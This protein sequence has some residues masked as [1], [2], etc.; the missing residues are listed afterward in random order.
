MS[1]KDADNSDNDVDVNQ[2]DKPL[3]SLEVFSVR[4]STIK[5]ELI[6]ALKNVASCMSAAS[7][8]GIGNLFFTM[9]PSCD[10]A[11][12]FSMN[13][14]KFGYYITEALGPFFHKEMIEDLTKSRYYSLAFD[15]TT[16]AESKKE[17]QIRI[18]Y[19]L[20]QE[21]K[22]VTKHLETVFIGTATAEEILSNINTV[23]NNHAIPKSSM[24]M[25]ASDGPNVNKKK[26][27]LL[28]EEIK[29]LRGK[30]L[31]DLGR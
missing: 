8:D 7:C 12:K 16:N 29:D 31:L 22:I 18:R 2:A 9:F 25:L 17:L 26:F 3:T 4:D 28:N 24:L 10:T 11:A 19:W 27:R 20:T 21:E 5:A 1:Q 6:W 14:T 15:E 13:R 30:S 23:L